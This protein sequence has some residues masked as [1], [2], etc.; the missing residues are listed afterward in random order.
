MNVAD[1]PSTSGHQARDPAVLGHHEAAGGR[2]ATLGAGALAGLV[3]ALVMTVVMVLLRSTL[4]ISPPPEMIPDRIAPLMPIPLF[5]W[6]LGTVG[7]Y[8]E[9]KQLGVGSILAGQLVVGALFGLLYATL[10]ERERAREP[11]SR[12][13]LGRPELVVALFVG[14]LWLVTVALVWPVLGTSYRGLP[15]GPAAIATALGLLLAYASY[16]VSLILAY[17][18][19]AGRA[20]SRLSGAAPRSTGRRALLVGGVGAILALTSGGLLRR[21]YG[22]ATFSYDGTRL[23][24]PDVAPVTSND[25]FYVVTKNVVDPSVDRGAW[26]FEV[27]GLVGRPQSYRF[28]DLATLPT[29]TQETTLMCIS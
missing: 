12:G 16:G 6:L 19:I 5:F 10:V 26:R 1:H 25:D 15:A 22:L 2:L 8:N 18:A 17:R 21:L 13:L 23:N 29:V 24:G 20:P 4:G 27:T 11:E 28:E 14:L 7:G 3:A 9:A